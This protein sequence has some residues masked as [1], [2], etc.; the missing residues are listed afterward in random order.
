MLTIAKEHG[1]HNWQDEAGSDRRQSQEESQTCQYGHGRAHQICEYYEHK[2]LLS[3]NDS[4]AKRLVRSLA[5]PDFGA[6]LRSTLGEKRRV[7][8]LSNWRLVRSSS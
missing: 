6:D 3:F 5:F 2:S 4:W 7:F 8:H 1:Q